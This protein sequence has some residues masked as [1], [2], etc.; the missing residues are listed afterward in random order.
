[1]KTT[2]SSTHR[3]HQGRDDLAGEYRY[4]DLAQ[5]IFLIIFL[6]VWITDMFLFN[7]SSFIS[8]YIP[9]YIE[10]PLGLVILIISGFVSMAGLKIVFGEVRDTPGVVKRGIFGVVRHPIYLGSI[11]FYLGLLALGFSVCAAVIWIIIIAFYHFLAKYE[12][13][14][15]LEKYGDEYARYMKAVPMWLPRFG[16]A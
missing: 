2:N 13:K 1:M 6:A 5:I 14:L 9:P 3:R 8:D 4:G 15:L 10:I 12:E 16:K 7:Y 11:L